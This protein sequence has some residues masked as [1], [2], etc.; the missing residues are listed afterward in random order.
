[1]PDGLMQAVRMGKWKAVR[2]KSNVPFELYDLSSDIGEKNNIAAEHPE[3]VGKIE[4][5]ISRDR[6][7]PRPQ[8][9]PDKPEGKKF[10]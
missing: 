1:M 4:A 7:E 3:I 6:V 10:R 8:I 5:Y 2:H 9:E